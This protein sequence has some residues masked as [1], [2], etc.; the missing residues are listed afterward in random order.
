MDNYNYPL[1]ADT[2]AAPW[3]QTNLPDREVEV[4]VSLCLSKTFKILVDDYSIDEDDEGHTM[5]DFSE[6]DLKSAIE[7][8]VIL[9]HELSDIIK[10]KFKDDIPPGL[11]ASIEDCS[12]WNVDDFEVVLE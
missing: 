4:C 9:P 7:N 12:D 10:N 11:K 3:N 2:S 5:P 6:C 1:G 8:L